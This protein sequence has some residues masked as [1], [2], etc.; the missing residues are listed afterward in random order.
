VDWIWWLAIGF[1]LGLNFG[2]ALSGVLR[3]SSKRHKN[4]ALRNFVAGSP[5]EGPSTIF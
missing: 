5:M 2:V 3:F 4:Q 1:V